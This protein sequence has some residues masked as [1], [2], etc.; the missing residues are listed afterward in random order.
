MFTVTIRT[1]GAECSPKL[2]HDNIQV[3]THLWL[4]PLQVS[5]YE[6]RV[7]WGEEGTRVE[8]YKMLT[9]VHIV[10][11]TK[12][13]TLSQITTWQNTQPYAHLQGCCA[14]RHQIKIDGQ[15]ERV[16]NLIFMP[17]YAVHIHVWCSI[18]SS[19]H[20]C[21]RKARSSSLRRNGHLQE[22][23]HWKL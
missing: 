19:V 9:C 11:L 3:Y 6:N 18:Y 16:W 15:E 21:K 7:W 14:L 5:P 1:L 13:K 20:G 22:R 8:S 23:H 17:E 2:P 4:L 12:G 10:N